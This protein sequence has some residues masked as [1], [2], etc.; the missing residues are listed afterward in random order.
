M[1]RVKDIHITRVNLRFPVNTSAT[2]SRTARQLARAT[3]SIADSRNNQGFQGLSNRLSGKDTVRLAFYTS[4]FR[5]IIVQSTQ[6][7]K[8]VD[9]A[10]TYGQYGIISPCSI[11]SG[12]DVT[13]S[14]GGRSPVNHS[15]KARNLL[16]ATGTTVRIRIR[17]QVISQRGLGLKDFIFRQVTNTTLTLIRTLIQARNHDTRSRLLPVEEGVR[18]PFVTGR[19]KSFKPCITLEVPATFIHDRDFDTLTTSETLDTITLPDPRPE[20][21]PLMYL[22]SEHARVQIIHNR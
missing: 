2:K 15:L 16:R 20:R 13:I 8:Q 18:D 12:V 10:I 5:T 6:V 1:L 21:T 11:V 19:I 9:S 17:S 7:R 4:N 22:I 14:I 3:T